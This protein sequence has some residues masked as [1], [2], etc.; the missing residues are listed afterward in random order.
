MAVDVPSDQ[1]VGSVVYGQNQSYP[2]TVNSDMT[3]GDSIDVEF[4]YYSID[5]HVNGALIGEIVYTP[6]PSVVL[7]ISE[8]P[9]GQHAF[10]RFDGN[11]VYLKDNFYYD[12]QYDHDGDADTPVV[13]AIRGFGGLSYHSNA[14]A[15]YTQE[16][17]IDFISEY[18]GVVYDRSHSNY[19]WYAAQIYANIGAQINGENWIQETRIALPD[20]TAPTTEIKVTPIAFDGYETGATIA[21]ITTTNFD[22]ASFNLNYNDWAFEIENNTIKLKDTWYVDP[23]TG[24]INS[25]AGYMTGFD[26]S[27]TFHTNIA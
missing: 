4:K 12:T 17:G 6:D 1:F 27:D 11:K 23:Y 2:D 8:H 22:S 21:N 10:F 13:P 7:T 20:W 18:D 16:G 25:T 14:N 15:Q 5:P 24:D 19:L 26:A 3:W 9:N